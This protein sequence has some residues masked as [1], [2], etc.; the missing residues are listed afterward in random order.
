MTSQ[1]DRAMRIFRSLSAIAVGFD[2]TGISLSA[3]RIGEIQ[4]IISYCQDQLIGD[5]AL[6]DQIQRQNICHLHDDQ[7]RFVMLIWIL[8][9]LTGADAVILRFI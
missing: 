5:D 9:H 4:D 8:Q 6:L 1:I 2:G 3:F 7:S